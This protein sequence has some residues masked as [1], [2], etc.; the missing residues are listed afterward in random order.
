MDM[1]TKI[2]IFG[3]AFLMFVFFLSLSADSGTGI[4]AVPLLLGLG[5]SLNS[6]GGVSEEQG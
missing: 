3:T 1:A 5:Q 2:K 6:I 4:V